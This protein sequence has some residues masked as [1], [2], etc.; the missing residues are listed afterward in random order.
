MIYRVRSI[1]E[2]RQAVGL[3]YAADRGRQSPTSTDRRSYLSDTGGRE[4][5]DP[6]R[7]PVHGSFDGS[8][9]LF[10]PLV[11]LGRRDRQRREHLQDIARA[12]D[13]QPLLEG[14][15]PDSVHRRVVALPTDRVLHDLD[16]DVQPLPAHVPDHLVSLLESAEAR[17]EV[18]SA[19]G[20]PLGILTGEQNLEATLRHGSI[21]RL[22]GKRP[23]P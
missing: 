5:H 21:E 19:L 17:H 3:Q 13:Q 11:D 6:P 15:P 2:Q 23:G 1:A 14:I 10:Y 9:E 22:A 20:G 16:A 8:F 4:L 12:R 7:V 18:L